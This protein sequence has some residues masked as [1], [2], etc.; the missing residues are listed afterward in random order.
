MPGR[1]AQ[2][3]LVPASLDGVLR[4]EPQLA[5]QPPEVQPLAAGQVIVAGCGELTGAGLPGAPPPGTVR[6]AERGF[7]LGQQ[8]AIRHQAGGGRAAR[9]P[10][11]KH[12]EPGPAGL[13]ACSHAV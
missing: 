4:L 3:G 6:Q 11:R 10:R 5:A 13:P 9:G 8:A 7:P 1:G 2:P 12:V